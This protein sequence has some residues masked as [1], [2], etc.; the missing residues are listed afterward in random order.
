[1]LSKMKIT[2]SGDTIRTLIAQK[3]KS[4]RQIAEVIGVSHYTVSRWAQ[5]GTHRIPLHIATQL[6]KALEVTTE[7]L[8]EAPPKEMHENERDWLDVYRKMTPLQRAQARLS[9]EAILANHAHDA[10][11][12]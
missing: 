11:G 10:G 5:S 12:S 1:M 9:V 7:D 2:A 8:T 4:Q 3:G 6:S